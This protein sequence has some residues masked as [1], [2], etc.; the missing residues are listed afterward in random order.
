MK[1]V[2]LCTV[3]LA[4]TLVACKQNGDSRTPK[5]IIISAIQAL[6]A[7]KTNDFKN[8]L[9]ERALEKYGSEQNQKALLKELGNLKKLKLGDEKVISQTTMGNTTTTL[10]SVDVMQSGQLI[11]VVETRCQETT[12]QS[13]RLVCRH[14]QVDHSDDYYDR[15]GYEHD[16][17]NDNDNDDYLRPGPSHPVEPDRGSSDGRKPGNQDPDRPGRYPMITE[18]SYANEISSDCE[19]VDDY[20]TSVNCKIVELK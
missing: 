2:I 10:S 17:G 3:L 15:P 6:N 8:L 14:D 1:K 7:K 12:T 16:R 5:G 19:Y 9:S 18:V 13:S 4:T 20:D 11:R